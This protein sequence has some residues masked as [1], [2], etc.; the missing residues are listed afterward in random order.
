MEL[1]KQMKYIFNWCD[2]ILETFGYHM[3]IYKMKNGDIIN[4]GQFDNLIHLNKR[5][6]NPN[7][8]IMLTN[9]IYKILI[10]HE[11]RG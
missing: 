2:P 10:K 5:F 6:D 8:Q 3:V 9:V 7:I 11:D 4:Q 1:D